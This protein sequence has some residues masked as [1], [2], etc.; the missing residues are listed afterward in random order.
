MGRG[1]DCR[2]GWC[3]WGPGRAVSLTYGHGRVGWLAG[4]A[5]GAAARAGSNLKFSPGRMIR[6]LFGSLP[7]IGR[8]QA[9][10]SSPFAKMRLVDAAANQTYF[11][12]NQTYPATIFSR[13]SSPNSV[14]T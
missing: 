6:L 11:I 7:A 12:A 9:T 13:I 2:V 4:A 14:L 1:V 3:G 8:T 5:R 10:H